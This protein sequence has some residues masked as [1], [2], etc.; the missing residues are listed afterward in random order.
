MALVFTKSYRKTQTQAVRRNCSQC[1]V[2]EL[3]KL[4]TTHKQ[5]ITV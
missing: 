4:A 2:L 3:R 1:K 5:E